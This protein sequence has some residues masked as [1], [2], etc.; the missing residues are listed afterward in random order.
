MWGGEVKNL[1]PCVFFM[2][3]NFQ[4]HEMGPLMKLY[5]KC[6]E[7]GSGYYLQRSDTTG[8]AHAL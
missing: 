4:C 5:I 3:S 7:T 6:Y 2:L 8:H 1:Y